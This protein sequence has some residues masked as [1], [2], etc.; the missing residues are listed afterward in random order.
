MS[1]EEGLLFRA[2]I[3]RMVHADAQPYTY[4]PQS[5][6]SVHCTRGHVCEPVGVESPYK[7]LEPMLRR[8]PQLVCAGGYV[9]RSIHACGCANDADLYIVDT[10]A[11][12]YVDKCTRAHTILHDC[13]KMIVAAHGPCNVL[14][15]RDLITVQ[16][17]NSA[18]YDND[19]SFQAALGLAHTIKYQFVLRIYDSVGDLLRGFDLSLSQVAMSWHGGALQYWATEL[20]AWSCD[21]RVCIVD[22]LRM[23][24]RTYERA[25]K[26]CTCAPVIL[27]GIVEHIV[28]GFARPREYIGEI[29]TIGRSRLYGAYD[30]TSDYRQLSGITYV[31]SDIEQRERNLL[32]LMY[33]KDAHVGAMT[34]IDAQT[35]FKCAVPQFAL[36]EPY[37]RPQCAYYDKYGWGSMKYCMMQLDG[38]DQWELMK[39]VED[40]YETRK[41]VIAED[42]S[43]I[44]MRAEKYELAE[45]KMHLYEQWVG[46]KYGNIAM[47]RYLR[48]ARRRYPFSLLPKDVFLIVLRWAL[49]F[50][51]SKDMPN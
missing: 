50:D 27:V 46:V 36:L 35:V 19:G 28:D 38:M 17:C 21:R 51:S 6:K 10:S 11:D 5:H 16:V 13:L 34:R 9:W 45:G 32:Y 49:V 47:E 7:A 37:R 22:P 44:R 15:T 14:H 23:H 29:F 8:W 48:L 43:E 33:D 12:A 40:E 18:W 26:Y 42:L 4:A 3:D 41:A 31:R 39:Y 24:P 25:C 2:K 30:H 1:I 20:G